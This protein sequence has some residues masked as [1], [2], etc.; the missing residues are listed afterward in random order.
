VWV[1]LTKQEERSPQMPNSLS[2]QQKKINKNKTQIETS[3]NLDPISSALRW[4][5]NPAIYQWGCWS[6]LV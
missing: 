5:A 3:V 4:C 2:L 1:S 6:M